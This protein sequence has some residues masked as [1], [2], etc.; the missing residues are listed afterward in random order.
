MN[1]QHVANPLTVV[2]EKDFPADGFPEY[3]FV[4]RSNVGKSSLINSL[5]S[6][7]NIAYISSKPGKTRTLNFYQIN[8]KF[9]IVDVPGY[10]YAKVSKTQREQ[11][12][13]MI[14]HYLSTR[15]E[16]KHIFVLL[17]LRHPPSEDDILMIDFLMYLNLPFT[18]LATK[19]DKV[20]TTRRHRHMKIMKSALDLPA[21]IDIIPY[22]A[23]THEGKEVVLDK[24]ER[25][26]KALA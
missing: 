15:N 2:E 10:G 25:L 4:G 20:S 9:Y 19:A 5:L 6:R 8:Q 23:L 26:S 3:L 13:R 14:E 16:L 17:D 11:F 24:L 21:D 12:A 7:K 22:S 1:I 18:I